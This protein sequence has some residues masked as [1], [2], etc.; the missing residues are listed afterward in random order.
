MRIQ[1][2]AH[3]PPDAA[4]ANTASMT[5]MFAI[6]SLSGVGAGRVDRMAAPNASA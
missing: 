2:T 5:V 6:A 1:Q 3:Q 4:L